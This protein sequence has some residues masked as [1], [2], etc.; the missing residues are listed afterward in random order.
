LRTHHRRELG[1]LLP[2]VLRDEEEELLN[3]RC[4]FSGRGMVGEGPEDAEGRDCIRLLGTV[5]GWEEADR[6]V[7]GILGLEGSS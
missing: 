5:V 7:S 2:D 4:K 1:S 6:C 3:W